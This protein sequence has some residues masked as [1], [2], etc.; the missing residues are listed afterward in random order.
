MHC[1]VFVSGCSVLAVRLLVFALRDEQV[2]APPPAQISLH[3]WAF[4]EGGPP[5]TRWTPFLDLPDQSGRAAQAVGGRA[6]G[7]V[8]ASGRWSI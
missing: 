1:A 6:G 4:E 5:L 7:G 3:A 2:A 8:A